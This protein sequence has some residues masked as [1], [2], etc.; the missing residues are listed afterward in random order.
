MCAVPLVGMAII[1]PQALCCIMKGC[2]PLSKVMIA[3]QLVGGKSVVR[4]TSKGDKIRLY[5]DCLFRICGVRSVLQWW[6][7]MVHMGFNFPHAG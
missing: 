3:T 6:Q 5:L 7:L 1:L 4:C 2:L